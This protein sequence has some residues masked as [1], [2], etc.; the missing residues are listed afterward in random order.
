MTQKGRFITLEG[1]E[2]TGKSTQLKLLQ[3]ALSSAGVEVTTTREPGGTPQAERIRNL[4]LQRDSGKFDPLTEVLMMFAARREHLVD[5]IWPD[6]ARGKWV[7]SDRFADSTRAFQGY[8][9]DIPQ[10]TIEK[11]YAL[12]AGDFQP[13][14]TFIFD[15]DPEAG[16]QRSLK[17]LQ[18]T[19]DAT[20]STE[21]R[22]ERMGIAF[23]TR[24]REG[25]L[26]IA[27]KF[28]DRCVV[29]DAAQDIDTVHRAML[30]AITERFGVTPVAEEARHG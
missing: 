20:E 3:R 26:E 24:L 16:L 18:V 17:Q 10:E 13:D 19:Q 15:I 8:G 14:L 6:M 2:G 30:D 7:I 29:I 21:D 11:V 27:K 25:F 4:L 28:P 12:V 23:H 5:K 22:Y 1:G 9:M